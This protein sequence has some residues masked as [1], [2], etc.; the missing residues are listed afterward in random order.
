MYSRALW[1]HG[2]FQKARASSVQCQD[3]R[4]IGFLGLRDCNCGTARI[5][6]ERRSLNLKILDALG[7][8][9]AGSL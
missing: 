6:A 3:P 2:R 4:A 8:L 1:Q 9:G 5:R 7:E